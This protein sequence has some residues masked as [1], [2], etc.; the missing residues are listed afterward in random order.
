MGYFSKEFVKI[1]SR[2]C[3]LFVHSQSCK[4]YF[5]GDCEKRSNRKYWSGRHEHQ[6]SL[7]HNYLCLVSYILA[8]SLALSVP[9]F[10][11]YTKLV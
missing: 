2:R 9:L 4:I 11:H 8:K 10:P 5:F 6:A 1:E 7:L 3:I